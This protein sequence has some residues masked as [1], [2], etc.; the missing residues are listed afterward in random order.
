[1]PFAAVN[2]EEI[3]YRE[4]NASA[5][6]VDGGEALVFVHSLG[7]SSHAW[8]EQLRAFSAQGF[9]AIAVDCRGHGRSTAR[10]PVTIEAMADDL[11]ALLDRLG[12]EQAHLAGLSMG[13]LVLMQMVL[14][15]SG[16][17]RSLAFCDSFVHLEPEVQ[18]QRIAAREQALAVKTMPEFGR[19]YVADTLVTGDAA[20]R[21]E[22]AA[23]IG[24][25]PKDVYLQAARACFEADVR[26]ALPRVGVATLVI[27]GD[28]D[29]GTPPEMMRS[30]TAQIAG[31][32]F[33]LIPEAAHV[34]NLD[35]PA[36]FNAALAGFLAEV[37]GGRHWLVRIEGDVAE[38]RG[39]TFAAC[40]ALPEQ[41]DIATVLPGM[42]GVAVRVRDLLAPARPA[43]GATFATFRAVDG[44][45]YGVHLEQVR[46]HGLLLYRQADGS[47]LP[48]GR[49]WPA[50]LLVP[51]AEA[52]C[53][54]VKGVAR[55]EI[56]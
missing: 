33:A 6:A 55:V 39:F 42:Q 49:G 36:A 48:A 5:T 26:A 14:R 43:E 27:G 17:V 18:Q 12:I 30:I 8:A 54:N 50:R 53:T 32:R 22:L 9:R 41:V 21:Q 16:K 56:Q 34:S 46:D 35:N 19:Q 38:P 15:H 40:A 45:S 28:R 52:N 25:M 37:R 31:A 23:V 1:M 20:V 44:F 11:A 47:P 7:S 4:E 29:K 24:R 51:G 3:F 10:G 2:G 13:G